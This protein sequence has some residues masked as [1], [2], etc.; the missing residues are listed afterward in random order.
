MA[1]RDVVDGNRLA[2]QQ[3]DKLTLVKV[4]QTDS[5]F[6]VGAQHNVVGRAWHHG[7]AAKVGVN[8]CGTDGACGVAKE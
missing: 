1:D 2:K 7:N 3:G 4:V 8:S 5:A 6:T